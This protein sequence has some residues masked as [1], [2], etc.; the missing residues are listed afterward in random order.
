MRVETR[1]S[2]ESAS[3]GSGCLGGG[4]RG[5]RGVPLLWHLLAPRFPHT[6]GREM[7]EGNKTRALETASRQALQRAR[8]RLLALARGQRERE[9]R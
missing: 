4:G 9:T 6:Q 8:R 2:G 7:N 5:R 1:G 3:S